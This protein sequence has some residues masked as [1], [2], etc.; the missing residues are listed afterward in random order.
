MV[1]ENPLKSVARRQ[2]FV[3]LDG[4]LATTLETK[5]FVFDDALWSARLLRDNPAALKGAH[6]EFLH[7][8]AD[9]I[10]TASYQAS[11]PGLIE[12]G[13]TEA[14]AERLLRLSVELAV[15]ARDEFWAL[16][17]NRAGRERPLVAA[18]VGPYGAYM[19][20]GSE[21]TGAYPVYLGGLRSFHE[22]RFVILAD[23][24]P[25]LLACETIPSG[26][27]AE[28]LLQLLS[29]H[30]DVWAW[31][32]LS[33]SDEDRLRDGTLVEEVVRRSERIDNVAALGVNCSHPYIM[34]DVARKL[35][36]I[37]N[38]PIILYPNSGEDYDPDTKRWIAGTNT[39][40][41]RERAPQWVALGACGVGGCCRVSPQDVSSIRA[42]LSTYAGR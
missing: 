30:P 38:K 12:A 8:G 33:C 16:E 4:G 15:D 13:A 29:E 40:D 5:R 2:G 11:I 6:R 35:K 22:R 31:L 25:D 27:E 37:S 19:A 23:A 24:G 1:S 42:G 28:V 21:Y 36:R 17:S 7:A 20:D 10:T 39:V 14:E 3:V 9:V 41:W 26:P 18:S 32:S 34:A